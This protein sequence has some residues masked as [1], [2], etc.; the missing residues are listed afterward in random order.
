M[1]SNIEIKRAISVPESPD[2][3][4]ETEG[5]KQMERLQVGQHEDTTNVDSG[6]HE[7]SVLP[8]PSTFGRCLGKLHLI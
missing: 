4:A 7:D 6:N 2:S 1:S 8:R 5:V 3:K